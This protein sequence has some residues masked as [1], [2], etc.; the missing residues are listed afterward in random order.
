MGKV[1]NGVLAGQLDMRLAPAYRHAE[2]LSQLCQR[3]FSDGGMLTSH[4]AS[5]RSV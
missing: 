5:P 1:P 3:L 4:A 2:A